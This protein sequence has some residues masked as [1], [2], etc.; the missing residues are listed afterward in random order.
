MRYTYRYRSFFWP[1]LLILAGL[2]A[3]LVNTGQIP[4][5]RLDQVLN[6]WPLVL[7]VIGLEL[8]VRRSVHGVTGDVAAAL[9]VLLAVVGAAAYVAVSPSPTAAH[10]LDASEEVGSLSEATVEVDAGAATISVVGK[11]DVGAALFRAHIDYSGTKPDVRFNRDS[12]RLTIST[13]SSFPFFSTQRR[14]ALQLGL[15][16][17]VVWK[18]ELNTGSATTTLALADV[19]VGSI[20][21]NTGASRDD[22]T[23]GRPSGNVPIEI[24]GGALTVAI[25][26]VKGTDASVEVSGA[27]VT[28]NADGRSQHAVGNLR[29]ETSGFSGA[30][31][32]YDISVN[33]GACTVTLDTAT[34]SG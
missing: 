7:V 31:D 13:R 17:A 12:G 5:E 30:T 16:P 1:A 14:F 6:L 23:L 19:R 9:I 27:A 33:G 25:H 2:I 4:A 3:L 18:I 11:K 29:F 24:N 8:I 22:I 26:R 32:R 10:S 20:S 21:L 28:L 15:N 34:A